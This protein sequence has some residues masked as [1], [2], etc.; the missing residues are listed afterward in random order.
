MYD[1]QADLCKRYAAEVNRLRTENIALRATIAA[2]PSDATA[3]QDRI[4]TLEQALALAAAAVGA[5]KE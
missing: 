4:T 2:F 3:M 5:G 1:L